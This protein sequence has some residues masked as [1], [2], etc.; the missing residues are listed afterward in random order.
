MAIFPPDFDEFLQE[1]QR[2][3]DRAAAIL[4]AAY[5]DA[6]LEEL[7]RAKFVSG[8]KFVEDLITGQGGLSSFS[9]RI[10]VAYAVGLIDSIVALDLHLV[11]RIRNDF[12]HKRQGL[13]FDTPVMANRVNEFRTLAALRDS[14]GEP[15]PLELPPRKRFNLA[16]GVLVFSGIEKRIAEMPTFVEPKPYDLTTKEDQ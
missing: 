2:E 13:S 3:S 8:P 9:A 12:S 14:T 11:R 7:L 15:L 6:R 1:F 4:G 5:I 10:G 16:V